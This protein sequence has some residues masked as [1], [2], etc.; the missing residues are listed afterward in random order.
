MDDE[1]QRQEAGKNGIPTAGGRVLEGYKQWY[2]RQPKLLRAVSLP[3]I[4][5]LSALAIEVNDAK[6][7][8]WY[9]LAFILFINLYNQY[10]EALLGDALSKAQKRLQGWKNHSERLLHLNNILKELV[11]NKSGM[12]LDTVD[13]A[14]KTGD[15]NEAIG[16]IR[17]SG[18]FEKSLSRIVAMLYK[19]F[20]KYADTHNNQRFRV[21]YLVPDD[22]GERLVAK[23]WYNIDQAPP[24]SIEDANGT[25]FSKGDR[26]VAGF[27]WGRDD[28]DS[29]LIDDVEKHMAT[30]GTDAMFSYTHGGQ[31]KYLKAILCHKVTDRKV[32]RCL[33]ILC[34]DTN[35]AG[36]LESY[37]KFYETVLGSFA[38]RIVFETRC[39]YMKKVLNTEEAVDDKSEG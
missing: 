8:W 30:E 7:E 14:R 32:H 4:F 12:F 21:T 31:P 23:A 17:A 34:V 6:A 29:I 1:S 5:G 10:L 16:K 20:E 11:E 19:V 38:K 27:L 3:T 13:V 28:H 9:L 22:T 24:V 18:S 37:Q 2:Y 25:Y 36:T 26:T 35:L 39:A 15:I 33:G